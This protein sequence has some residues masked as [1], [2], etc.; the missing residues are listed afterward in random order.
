M[1]LA[2]IGDIIGRAGR[3]G[4]AEHLPRLRRRLKLDFVMVNAENAAGGFGVTPSV[5]E[6][7]FD[8]GADILTTGNH[9]F[10]QRD[11]L[12][13]FDQEMRLLRPANFPASNPGRGSALKQTQ[14]GA[15]V[16]VINVQGQIMMPPID[17]PGA[18][19]D[20]ELE[21]VELGREA[22]A[23]LVDMH[24]EAT[25]EKYALGH[26]LNGRVTAV[27][28]THTHVPTADAHIMS[29]GSAFMADLGMSGDYDSVIGMEKSEPVNRFATK[30]NRNR[31]NPATGPATVCGLF[32]E[33]DAGGRAVRAEPIRVG[34]VLSEALPRL[35]EDE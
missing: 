11:D 23:I 32:V 34:G 27:V 28:G 30:M 4:L 10:D 5:C 8:A 20:R 12:D 18:A 9:A 31:F 6:E 19:V 3:V 16:L 35:S 21:G 22:D 26:Y 24:A 17:D 2:L 29:R 14:D 33:T 1:R 25:S 15:N 13:L 7:L